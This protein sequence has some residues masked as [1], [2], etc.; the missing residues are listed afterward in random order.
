MAS[1]STSE[2]MRSSGTGPRGLQALGDARHRRSRFTAIGSAVS[3]DPCSP[4]RRPRA[5][6]HAGRLRPLRRLPARDPGAPS[7]WSSHAHSTMPTWRLFADSASSSTCCRRTTRARTPASSK[8]PGDHRARTRSRRDRRRV[9][10]GRGR[11]RSPRRSR[12]G[13]RP[14]HGAPPRTS[15]AGTCSASAPV[16]FVGLSSRTNREGAAA[17]ERWRVADGTRGRPG[18]GSW[19]PAPQVGMQ[20]RER[21]LLLHDPGAMDGAGARPRFAA[22]AW[23]PRRP[24]EAVGA[25]VLAG[26]AVLV[27]AAAPG[28]AQV[29]RSPGARRARRRVGEFHKGD[30]AL[31]CLSLRVPGAGAWVT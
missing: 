20:P 4:L 10:P 2:A 8:T 21:S 5:R 14:P 24:A 26:G 13:D 15:T 25:N 27:S 19:R 3:D 7:T 6:R 23:S 17:L 9:T 16:L 12:D 22:A 30:G 1:T 11:A 31:T 18:R 29:L 28:T